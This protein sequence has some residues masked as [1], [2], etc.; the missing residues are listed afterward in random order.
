[1]IDAVKQIFIVGGTALVT[2]VV[3][4]LMTPREKRNS[5]LDVINKTIQ[6][7]LESISELTT[8]VRAVTEELVS[9]KA[10]NLEL[11]NERSALLQE[12]E[13]MANKITSLE[14]KVTSLT[15]VMRK[16]QKDEKISDT[17]TAPDAD[18]ELQDDKNIG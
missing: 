15:S 10:K 16:L 7:L 14:K 8:H 13:A 11:I 3:S 12:V 9:E 1:M 18:G 5:D 4:K 2:W 6:P 17:P